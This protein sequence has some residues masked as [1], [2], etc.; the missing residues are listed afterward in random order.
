[1][2]RWKTQRES[3]RLLN[4]RIRHFYRTKQSQHKIIIK[5][6]AKSLIQVFFLINN[7]QKKY[8]KIIFRIIFCEFA[9]AY[10]KVLKCI[11]SSWW[12]VFEKRTT[13]KGTTVPVK[14]ARKKMWYNTWAL[15]SFY[16]NGFLDFG[17]TQ[18]GRC[19]AF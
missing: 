2:S 7:L 6:M 18:I 16:S 4:Q 17:K 9:N 13:H 1:M 14:V 11:G 10:S 3:E 19:N 12:F 8:L 5:E 15:S